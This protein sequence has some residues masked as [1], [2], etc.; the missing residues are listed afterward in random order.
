[1]NE[2]L[3][4]LGVF[5]AGT[6]FLYRHRIARVTKRRLY[7][8]PRLFAWSVRRDITRLNRPGTIHALTMQTQWQ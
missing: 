4:S 8:S 7:T 1:M 5:A 2:A 3:I 6:A